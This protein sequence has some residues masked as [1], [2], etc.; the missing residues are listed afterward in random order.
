MAALMNLERTVRD[1]G[2][3]PMHGKNPY[4]IP[5]VSHCVG[6]SEYTGPCQDDRCVDAQGVWLECSLI[7]LLVLPRL[8]FPVA[9]ADRTCRESFVQCL[10]AL[11]ELDVQKQRQR[12][13]QELAQWLSGAPAHHGSVALRDAP[14]G[15][16]TGDT[17]WVVGPSGVV[18]KEE[19]K[20]KL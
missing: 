19:D 17:V 14:F 6:Q 8:R 1:F 18:R 4:N 7:N 2:R 12:E 15:S 10:Q 3:C 13:Q 20:T 9:C 16:D 5:F 11:H